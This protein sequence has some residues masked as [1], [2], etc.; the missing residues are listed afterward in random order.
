MQAYP[1][2]LCPVENLVDIL[3]DFNTFAVHDVR[4]LDVRVLLH[5]VAQ[6]FLLLL[7]DHALYGRVHDISFY[8]MGSHIVSSLFQKLELRYEDLRHVPSY[9]MLYFIIRYGGY[10]AF[11]ILLESVTR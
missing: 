7:G 2:I 10:A 5:D 8:Q 11:I 6:D 9:E 1:V 3:G 4:E